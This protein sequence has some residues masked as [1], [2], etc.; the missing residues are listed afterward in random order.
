MFYSDIIKMSD[1]S[2]ALKNAI[3]YGRS[4]KRNLRK[5]LRFQLTISIS[6]VF[7]CF[8]STILFR[9][10]VLPPIQLLWV[11]IIMDSLGSFALAFDFQST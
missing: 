11:N 8:L 10:F 3:E 6:L 9:E 2:T 4:L 7:I 5:F 1:K